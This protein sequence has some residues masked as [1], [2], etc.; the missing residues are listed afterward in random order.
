MPPKW[1]LWKPYLLFLITVFTG[2]SFKVGTKRGHKTREIE[3]TF[4][5]E[6]V[7]NYCVG[8]QTQRIE[9]YHLKKKEK[10]NNANTLQK[11]YYLIDLSAHR[12]QKPTSVGRVAAP[13][14]DA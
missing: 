5:K 13:R 14:V 10:K 7:G 4:L 2:T 8:Y 6:Q 11:I 9:Q 3:G 1:I 12:P